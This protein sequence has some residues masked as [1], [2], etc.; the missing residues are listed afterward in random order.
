M[1]NSVSD[2]VGHC[3]CVGWLQGFYVEESSDAEAFRRNA[4]LLSYYKYQSTR[5][6]DLYAL[7]A[8]MQAI[9]VSRQGLGHPTSV[10]S[11]VPSRQHCFQQL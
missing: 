11:F 4:K 5:I 3:E 8:H 7:N 10:M 2:S 1:T 9:L 6:L